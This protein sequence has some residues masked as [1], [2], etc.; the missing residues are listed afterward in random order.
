MKKSILLLAIVPFCLALAACDENNPSS[1]TSNNG[2]NSSTTQLTN[3]TDWTSQAKTL[4]NE[5]LGVTIPFIKL[6]SNYQVSLQNDEYGY[7]IYIADECEEDLVSE[8]YGRILESNGFT[9]DSSDDSDGY[10][11]YLY[12]KLL[13]ENTALIVQYDFV[14][15]T[16]DYA[17]GNEIYAWLS[18]I[19]E[20]QP[21]DAW[22]DGCIDLMT[23]YLGT[24]IPYVKLDNYAYDYDAE[25]NCVIIYDTSATNL[26]TN[27]GTIL[28]NN[29]FTYDTTYEDG[30]KL[31]HKALDETSNCCIEFGFDEKTEEY[32]GGNSIYAYITETTSTEVTYISEWS[33]EDQKV[34]MDNLGEVLP[35]AENMFSSQ[36]YAEYDEF[37]S[38]VSIYDQNGTA[39]TVTN[40]GQLLAENGFTY[41]E[42]DDGY[43]KEC[44]N[45][46][47]NELFVQVY[48]IDGAG[49]EIDIY[50]STIPTD[51]TIFPSE[52]IN[53]FFNETVNIPSYEAES[54][55]YY[56]DASAF[57]I[58]SSVTTDPSSTYKLALE[59]NNYTISEMEMEGVMYYSAID[60]N[61]KYQ[62]VFYYYNNIFSMYIVADTTGGED[63]PNPPVISE[64][65][66][67]DVTS[68]NQLQDGYDGN[69]A[70]WVAGKCTMTITKNTSTTNVGNNSYF[71]GEGGK[72]RIYGGQK[73][74]FSWDASLAPKTIT[75]EVD[76]N[77]T[78][79]V[80]AFV[81][82]TKNNCSITASGNIVTIT[83][84]DNVT[85]CSVVLSKQSRL[86]SVN[87]NF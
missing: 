76:S 2:G 46:A 54:Y 4:M 79:Y 14:P 13:D 70:V 73:I 50:V 29:G 28:E 49:V 69:E 30:Y 81:N 68:P 74:T 59:N 17:A 34:M 3:D 80:N 22:S 24:T 40:Y 39:A 75:I 58:S 9:F 6:A 65:G 67:F 47:D 57:Y 62:V 16:E 61:N 72:C 38:C 36:A 55:N 77:K 7:F 56:T 18:A 85:E 11:C 71:Y 44:V 41:S 25:Q 20:E 23:Q 48:Y 5:N 21:E 26:L 45:I 52:E 78:D 64:E 37:Y 84:A 19:E 63:N 8:N 32:Y 12:Q 1:N 83:I 51:V 33:Q 53:T 43:F 31:Y 35:I 66:V 86:L 42:A 87:F 82:G 10:Y 15:A 60:A 27:Y